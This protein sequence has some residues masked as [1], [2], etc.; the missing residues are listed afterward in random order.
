MFE[1]K[2]QPVLPRAKFVHRL[3]RSL[4]LACVVAAV[5]LAGGTLGYCHFGE[6]GFID[7]FLNAAMILTGM[8]PVDR[9][10]TDGGKLFAG[11]YALYSGMAFL[12]MMAVLV[13]PFAHR[14]LHR[15]HAETESD[16][17]REE[18]GPNDGAD[19]QANGADAQA[20]GDDADEVTKRKKAK[21]R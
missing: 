17:E 1:H 8:G 7:G 20:D 10:T 21:K 13:A 4:G 19:A 6:L 2:R 16:E 14:M 18:D 3:T 5:S 12:T 9:M 11:F 15:L